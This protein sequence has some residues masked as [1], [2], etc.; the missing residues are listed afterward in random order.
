VDVQYLENNRI[1]HELNHNVQ[2]IGG[3]GTYML[4]SERGMAV[5]F[6]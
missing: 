6:I 5:S 2:V 4:K 1:F 3:G